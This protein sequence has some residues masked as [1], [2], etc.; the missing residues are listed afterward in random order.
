MLGQ[1]RR[2][3]AGIKTAL[4]DR[5]VFAGTADATPFLNIIINAKICAIT[6]SQCKIPR[7]IK[8]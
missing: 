1:R 8:Y 2:R 4:V 7:E 5:L 6:E 3:W